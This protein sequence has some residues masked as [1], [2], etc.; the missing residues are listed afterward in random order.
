MS[1]IVVAGAD[2]GAGAT[3]AAVGLAHRLAYA[4][5][6]VRI[7]RLDGDARAAGDAE[8]LKSN[9]A[10][11]RYFEAMAGRAASPKAVANWV[12]NTLQARLAAGPWV[13]TQFQPDAPAGRRL[14]T[15]QRRRQAR[16][17]AGEQ[18]S[19]QHLLQ[20]PRSPA[21]PVADQA[22][23]LRRSGPTAGEACKIRPSFRRGSSSGPRPPPAG[24]HRFCALRRSNP[25]RW[26]H[27]G[28]AHRRERCANRP[29]GAASFA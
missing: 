13:V 16:D 25:V 19:D 20:C 7:E 3:T 22:A 6:S 27:P 26:V 17:R 8:V 14:R 21:A 5:H 4:G 29:Q 15:D 9:V 23:V 10:L 2:A 18:V 28:R 11:G 1:V 24:P 12:I